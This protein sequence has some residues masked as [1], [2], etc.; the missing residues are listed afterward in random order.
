MDD[1]TAVGIAEGFYP[2]QNYEHEIE[3]WQHLI[4]TGLCW[5]LQGWFG[6]T[7]QELLD[8]G[9]CKNANREKNR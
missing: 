1:I 2:S 5:K 3:A 9:K 4:D 7:A 6:R 8:T